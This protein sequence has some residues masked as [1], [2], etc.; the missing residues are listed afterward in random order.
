MT[1]MPTPE[2]AQ[3]ITGAQNWAA[4][5]ADFP[6]RVDAMAAGLLVGDLLADA[7]IDEL[8][9]PAGIGWQATVA[10]LEQPGAAAPPALRAF[11]N[12]TTTMPA[13]FEPELA[14]AGADAWWRFGSLQS[15]TLYQSLIYGY[16]ARG[17]TRPLVETG[18]LTTGTFDRVQ[19][20]A[21][22]VALA[23]APGFMAAGAPGWIETLRIRLVHA[24]VRHHLLHGDSWQVEQYGVPINQTYCQLTITAG[25]LALPLHIAKDFG[26]RYSRA[27]L[28]AIT[29]L[30]RWIGW[31]MGVE[32]AL[33]PTNFTDATLTHQISKRFELRPDA[34]SRILV[35][36]LLDDGFRT[37]L[38]LP[39][40]LNS[41]VDMLARPVLRQVF[42]AVSTR[43][44]E[45]DVAKGM[46]LRTNPLHH[47]V[48]LA[49]PVV[50]SREMA[51]ALGLFGSERV[52]AQRELRLVTNRIG[53]DLSNLSSVAS[54]YS[55]ADNGHLDTVA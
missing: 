20:T 46:G 19:A 4:V 22:W 28:E 55:N 41:A 33:L 25:F 34:E 30:W 1:P 14:R 11:L 44:V 13:W 50:R 38:G 26:V 21:R 29:H 37:D 6:E 45:P 5:R 51:R 16:Q 39:R 47:L 12:A 54:R 31:C 43:W 18:R 53:L 8:F 10:A 35:K 42:A 3:A 7:V 36:A 9:S 24:M 40:P 23:T 49:R 48:D 52:V 15:S 17:F 2:E 32:E 27:D